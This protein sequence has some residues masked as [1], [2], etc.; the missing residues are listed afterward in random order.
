MNELPQD[1]RGHGRPGKARPNR[2]PARHTQR[3]PQYSKRKDKDAR[4][5]R[6]TA[7]HTQRKT[8]YS[9]RNNKDV[10]KGSHSNKHSTKWNHE[11][12]SFSD[13]KIRHAF[14]QKV[15]GIV[16]TQIAFT[17]IILC[18]FNY[19]EPIQEFCEDYWWISLIFLALTIIVMIVISCGPE[20]LRRTCPWNVLLLCLFTFFFSFSVAISTAASHDASPRH[21]VIM[22]FGITAVIVVCITLFAFQTKIDFTKW[23][24]LMCMLVLILIVLIIFGVIIGLTVDPKFV[25]PIHLVICCVG[26][27]I[28]C[29]L[30]IYDTQLIIGGKA[31]KYSLNPED[32]VLGALIIYTDIINL[33]LFVYDIISLAS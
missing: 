3:K 22:A 25:R 9:K 21:C 23:G 18:I 27:L 19:I 8:Q 24:G 6:A 20:W 11:N 26:V 29:I 33:F 13:T 10:E 2:V 28:I 15:Y 14:I 17:M 1:D 16:L 32:Y 30:L 5:N 31:H 12:A 7:R 4:P